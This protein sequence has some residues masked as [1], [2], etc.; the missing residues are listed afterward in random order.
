MPPSVYMLRLRSGG[1]YVG[2][3]TNVDRRFVEHCAGK[4]GRSTEIDPPVGIVYCEEMDNVELAKTRERQIKHWT[5]AK[6]EALIRG[7]AI[8]LKSLSRRRTR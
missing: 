8:T 1:L 2:W 4:G 5:R 6:K 7:D 3:S